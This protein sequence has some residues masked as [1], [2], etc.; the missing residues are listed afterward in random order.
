MVEDCQ[1]EYIPP[2]QEET[3]AVIGLL[4]ELVNN[5]QQLL[6]NQ[7]EGFSSIE[8]LLNQLVTMAGTPSTMSK[9]FSTDETAISIATPTKP[10]SPDTIA[11]PLTGTP[12]YDRI[13]VFQVL[14]RNSPHLSVI[15][16]GTA[17]LFVIVSHD[18]QIWSTD[19]NPIL[20]GEARLFHNVYELRLRS[21]VAGNVALFTGGVYR[22]TEYDY[23]LAYSN[24]VSSAAINRAAF[25][26]QSI[27][28][29][30][31]PGAGTQLPPIV[32][33]NGFQLVIRATPGNAAVVYL[34]NSGANTG[35]AANRITLAAG[36]TAKLQIT[37]ANLVWVASTVA[38][39]S[40]DILAEQ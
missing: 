9:Y 22:A 6:N 11:D 1:V 27:T 7:I 24:A 18:G 5:Q 32:M 8:G 2:S 39:T 19:E 34:A 10:S 15:N 3:S 17:S 40:V 30:G 4:Q 14:D 36:D 29:I 31:I 12:G 28:P 21:P 16:D 38:A 26:A 33:P 25:T 35:I 20:V 23:W 13:R 37:N